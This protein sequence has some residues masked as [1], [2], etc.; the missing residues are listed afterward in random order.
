MRLVIL[1]NSLLFAPFIF[2]IVF[3]V[4][5]HASHPYVKRE[6]TAAS[7]N[8]SF[9]A[10][11]TWLELNKCLSCPIL[12]SAIPILRFR[13]GSCDPSA[14]KMLPRYLNKKTFFSFSPSHIT[15]G[16][17]CCF[18]CFFFITAFFSATVP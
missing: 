4:S 10:S 13:S 14:A 8:F 3:G 7:Y 2:R 1:A 17:S 9:V 15:L 12:V 5:V 18:S 16:L 11:G 6:T